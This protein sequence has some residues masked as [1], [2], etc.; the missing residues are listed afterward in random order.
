[1]EDAED[2]L[3]ARKYL[4]LPGSNDRFCKLFRS[5]QPPGKF[6][7]GRIILARGSP[8]ELACTAI[9]KFR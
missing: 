8:V 4:G 2:W 9:H 5:G 6:H 7:E 3:S 1:M